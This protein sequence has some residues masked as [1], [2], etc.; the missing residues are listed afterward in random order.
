[1]YC[2]H[3]GKEVGADAS[4]CAHC[5]GKLDGEAQ[6]L[7]AEKQTGLCCPSCGS[8]SVDAQLYQENKG[9]KTKSKTKSVY[10]QKGHGCL[11]WAFIGWWWWMFDLILW[12]LIFPIRFLIQLFKKKTYVGEASTKGSTK[13]RVS[14]KTV[15]L[16]K[17]C[18]HHWHE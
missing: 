2:K 15:Y 16:C 12:V 17:D 7:P 4:F 13:N 9:S 18:G 3:C 1:M 11:W 14:Y 10:R 5:G 6:V 8:S